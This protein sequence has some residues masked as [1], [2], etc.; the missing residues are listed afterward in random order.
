L[1][2]KV[3][4][5][6]LKPEITA[7]GIRCADHVALLYPQNMA[8]TLPTSS[9]RSQTNATELLLLVLKLKS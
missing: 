5:L 8:P 3:M 1:K 7:E 2:E 6:V 9:G 4:A